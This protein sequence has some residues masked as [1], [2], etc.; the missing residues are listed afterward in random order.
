MF[1][2]VSRLEYRNLGFLLA[3]SFRQEACSLVLMFPQVWALAPVTVRFF[4]YLSSECVASFWPESNFLP[5]Q[6]TLMTCFQLWCI[7]LS[8]PGHTWYSSSHSAVQLLARLWKSKIGSFTL[9]YIILRERYQTK[10]LDT[11][12]FHLYETMGKAGHRDRKQIDGCW[13]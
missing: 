3:A 10:K 5:S 8:L 1:A 13:G 4:L 6:K 9:K 12:W 11:V 2:M 7:S